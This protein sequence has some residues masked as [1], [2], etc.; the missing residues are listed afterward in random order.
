MNS[1]FDIGNNTEFETSCHWNSNIFYQMDS[2]IN[3]F[4]KQNY[5]SYM[6]ICLLID[7]IKTTIYKITI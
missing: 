7:K 2:A 3:L 6:Y 4:L 1:Y 5:I